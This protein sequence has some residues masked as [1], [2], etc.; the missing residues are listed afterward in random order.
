MEPMMRERAGVRQ[1]WAWWGVAAGVCGFV[2]H[3]LTVAEL[4]EPERA[5]GVDV[6]A[7]LDR[8]RFHAGVV[9]GFAAIVAVLAFT[10]GWRRWRR[11]HAPESLAADVVGLGL[12]ASAGAMILG[13]GVKGMLAIYLPGGINDQ[14]HPDEGLYTLFMFDDLV[15]FMAWTGVA[16]AAGAIA[17]LALAERRLPLWLGVVGALVALAPSGMLLLTGLSGFP[18]IVGPL[19]MVVLG[20]GMARRRTPAAVSVPVASA[21]GVPLPA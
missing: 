9:A 18:G 6:V 13:Y 8:N 2:G 20:I 10:A 19:W 5:T 21:P 7:L 17:V 14:T 12:V 15:P 1:T 16:I 4:T 11:A 3:A